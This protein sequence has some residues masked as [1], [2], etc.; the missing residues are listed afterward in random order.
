MRRQVGWAVSWAGKDDYQHRCGLYHRGRV[1]TA[2]KQANI[3]LGDVFRFDNEAHFNQIFP[4]SNIQS[5]LLVE[6]YDALKNTKSVS[7]E[8]ILEDGA[9]ITLFLEVIPPAIQLLVFGSNY[10]VYPM[11]RAAKEL[12]WR[13]ICICNP[14]KIIILIND[15][16]VCIGICFGKCY[17]LFYF[18]L[19]PFAF[20]SL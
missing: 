7:K 16:K 14:V 19:F 8:Y 6:I 11:V 13:V 20:Q 15:G 5:N 17:G 12:G 3:N 1:K 4:L 9:K 18:S 2:K 10:D